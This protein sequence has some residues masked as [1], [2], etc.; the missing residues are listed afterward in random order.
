[1]GKRGSVSSVHLRTTYV[2]FCQGKVL[3]YK[4]DMD[5]INPMAADAVVL[6][7]FLLWF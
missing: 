2:I 7:L 3:V 4:M 5:V 6:Q 1:M